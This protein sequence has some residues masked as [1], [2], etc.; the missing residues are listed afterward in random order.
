MKHGGDEEHHA[1]TRAKGENVLN[2]DFPP[3]S[4][5]FPPGKIYQD[6]NKLEDWSAHRSYVL[7]L[8]K[9]AIIKIMASYILTVFVVLCI[10][11]FPT[12]GIRHTIWQAHPV[13]GL[14][15]I[16]SLS[17]APPT[18]LAY[19]L[20]FALD[21][22]SA[23]DFMD[24]MWDSERAR[25]IAA[26]EDHDGD[27]IVQ[28]EERIKESAEWL[29]TLLKGV[30]PIANPNLYAFQLRI[31]SATLMHYMHRFNSAIDLLED[32]MQASVPKFIVRSSTS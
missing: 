32:I 12:F 24:H 26:G 18:L 15:V 6:S 27:G 3:P 30:W 8:T 9:S 22:K 23:E 1:D 2:I 17:L 4:E 31:S 20:L 7:N 11:S 19:S 16:L 5:P 21:R 13:V 25:G 28:T 29:N 14:G 10:S